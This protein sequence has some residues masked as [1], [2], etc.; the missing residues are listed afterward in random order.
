MGGG[1]VSPV[2]PPRG[3]EGG[4]CAPV[5]PPCAEEGRGGAPVSPPCAGEKGGVHLSG[6]QGEG[7]TWMGLVPGG[8]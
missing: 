8:W 1:G 5:R 7:G 2:R 6:H 3:E 4:E